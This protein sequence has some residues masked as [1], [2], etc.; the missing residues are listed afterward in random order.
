MSD[1]IADMVLRLH[2]EILDHI[3]ENGKDSFA[4]AEVVNWIQGAY[5]LPE[6][7]WAAFVFGQAL[8]L[9][10]DQALTFRVIE[11]G[12]D[13]LPDKGIK[14]RSRM[15]HYAGGEHSSPLGVGTA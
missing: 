4:A 14:I 1:P 11:R 9:G 6:R 15:L 13:T 8:A 12:L 7:T 2:G 10:I 3:L 5:K